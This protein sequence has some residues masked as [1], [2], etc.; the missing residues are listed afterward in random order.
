M[1]M[2]KIFSFGAGVNIPVSFAK[3]NVDYSFANYRTLGIAQRLSVNL[4][5]P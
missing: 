1:W 5:F 3:A 2:Q 4:L